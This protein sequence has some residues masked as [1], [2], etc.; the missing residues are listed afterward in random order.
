MFA[1]VEARLLE[2]T[3]VAVGSAKHSLSA[4][5]SAEIRAE[6]PDSRFH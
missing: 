6:V 4:C 3:R 5:S 2:S 1:A